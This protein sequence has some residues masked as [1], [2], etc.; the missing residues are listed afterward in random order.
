MIVEHVLLLQFMMVLLVVM[1][2][3]MLAN[4]RQPSSASVRFII[5]QVE[6]F[7][8]RIGRPNAAGT[9][10]AVRMPRRCITFVQRGGVQFQRCAS[11]VP[12]MLTTLDVIL[13]RIVLN[14]R[15]GAVVQL[16]LVLFGCAG[17]LQQQRMRSIAR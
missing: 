3:L 17:R 1:V 8:F 14:C 12:R 15:R 16:E 9:G 11:L 7:R 10:A 4:V 5:L 13:I 6:Q 2:A